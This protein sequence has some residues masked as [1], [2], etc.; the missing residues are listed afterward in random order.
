MKKFFIYLKNLFKYANDPM[1]ELHENTGTMVP[2]FKR[3][4]KFDYGQLFKGHRGSISTVISQ[5]ESKAI[6]L[7]NSYFG[8]HISQRYVIDKNKTYKNIHSNKSTPN[9]L[10]NKLTDLTLAFN[11]T[12]N[13]NIT[14]AL[15]YKQNNM[16]INIHEDWMQIEKRK[17]FNGLH[18]ED[19]YDSI[20]RIKDLNRT[21]S[22]LKANLKRRNI[23]TIISMLAEN[24][25]NT[26]NQEVSNSILTIELDE[27]FFN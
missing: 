26:V 16:V 3:I 4:M 15:E 2:D 22:V 5:N 12:G 14:V 23:E 20:N 9:W 24:D 21:I 17:E 27:R 19:H 18:F 7:E 1:K 13:N 8:S 6:Y 10:K 11:A 25:K